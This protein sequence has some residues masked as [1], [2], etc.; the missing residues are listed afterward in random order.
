MTTKRSDSVEAR[1]APPA[2]LM[3][4]VAM[5]AGS[6]LL[7]ELV[8][9]RILSVLLFY[10]YSFFAVSLI[11]SGLALGGL[12][13]AR[14]NVSSMP[15]AEF[16]RL[17]TRLAEW[18]SG[19][20]LFGFG[21]LL[22]VGG[23]A[24]SL[25]SPLVF[26]LCFALMFLPGLSASGAFL[27][28]AFARREAWVSRL[29]AG[30]LIAAALSCLASIQALRLF[31]GPASLLIPVMMC[32]FAGLA[33]S[34]GAERGARKGA[35]KGALLCTLVAVCLLTAQVAGGG[36]LLRIRGSVESLI[37]R[38]NEH[39]RIVVRGEPEN[40]ELEIVIDKSAATNLIVLPPRGPAEPVPYS[41]QRGTPWSKSAWYLGRGAESAAILGVGGGPDVLMAAAH[42]ARRIDA[43]EL[44]GLIVDLH[45]NEFLEWN[46]LARWPEVDLIHS[47]ARVG[48]L[49]S[50]AK[51]DVIQA[52]MTDT[53]AATAGGGFVLSE[54]GLY[55]VEGWRIFLDALTEKGVLTMT[56]WHVPDAPAEIQRLVSLAV[57]ALG[58]TGVTD[59]AAHIALVT[60][61][62]E[63]RPHPGPITIATILVSRAPFGRGELQ[64]LQEFCRM[65]DQWLA[66]VP[67]IPVADPVFSGLLD[68]MTHAATVAASPYDISAPRDVRPYF[69]LQM[70]LRDVPGLREGDLGFI[71]DITFEAMRVLM[72]LVCVALVFALTVWVAGAMVFPS[73]LISPDARKRCRIMSVYF[74]GIGSGYILVQLA[75]HQRL[76]LIL[77]HPTYAL[78]VVLFGML[79][80]T[81][82]GSELSVRLFPGRRARAAWMIITAT[83]A[84]LLVGFPYLS[85]LDSIAS[86][87]ARA[88][89]AGLLVGAVGF[90]LGFGFPLGVRLVAPAG[91]TAVQRMWAVNGAASIAASASA[92]VIG[93]GFGSRAVLGCG[94]LAYCVVLGIGLVALRTD[95]P[96]ETSA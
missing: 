19:L 80:G 77:G 32:G 71:L 38:W 96:S 82:L 62:P 49:H 66:I 61:D 31:G 69:F 17:L 30:D 20:T 63:I 23:L 12:A 76:I 64:R 6:M 1:G 65:T 7:T 78:S 67:G 72:L 18:S 84:V 89:A 68:P 87:F 44:N 92:A 90:V 57:V 45:N 3:F 95:A 27:A 91:G 70:R 28:S 93:I 53:W 16:T 11:M 46:G 48:L 41:R 79:I 10:H 37:E 29:Y 5:V 50:G 14:L 35:R 51:Y 59:P 21:G 56:R 88:S 34:R 86:G 83:L 60:Q 54:N 74:F 47:E 43:Y 85:A 33:I 2:R 94:L 25:K 55:T 24:D 36:R 52:S 81:G 4:A 39:S 15:Q 9:T 26:T 13:A 42:G 75:L 58:E 22:Q 40:G 73:A 8:L